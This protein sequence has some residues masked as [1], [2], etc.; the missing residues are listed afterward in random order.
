M[1]RVITLLVAVAHP[2]LSECG[3]REDEPSRLVLGVGG[4]PG[5]RREKV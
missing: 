5:Q 2:L 1:Q 4:A 3:E